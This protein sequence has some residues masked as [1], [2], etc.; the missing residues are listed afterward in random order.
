M[1]F[2]VKKIV[3][4]FLLPPGV[5]IVPIIVI[6]L[7]LIRSR[8]WRIGMVN[9]LIGLA[10]WAFSTAPVA[11]G[12]MQ[13][14]ES[15]FSFPEKPSG[16]AIILLG[17]A[18]LREVPDFSGKGAPSPS[19]TSRIVTAVRLYRRMHLPIIVTGGRVYEDSPI[20]EATI[21]RRF[22]MDLGVP[23]NRIIMED[24]ARDTAQ[25][26][27][28]SAAICRRRGFSKP[29]LLTAAY[30]LKRAC[31][32]FEASG[33]RVTPFPAYFLGAQGAYYGPRHL[34]PNSGALHTSTMALHEYW[35]MLYYR[36]IEL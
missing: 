10:L 2:A 19:M 36:L 11:N 30:H 25:N 15:G 13:G 23:D 14:L 18:V 22:L 16:D 17:G 26:A 35:G 1:M 31:M 8:R 5:F 20:A 7:L 6:G 4:P 12:L 28:L 32:A 34:L 33:L 3:A 9:L 21:I 27:R 29:I 24:H